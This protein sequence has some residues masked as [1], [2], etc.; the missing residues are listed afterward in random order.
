M[1][2]LFPS[3]PSVFRLLSPQHYI[4]PAGGDG[5]YLVVDEKGVFRENN[6]Q[7]ALAQ[8]AVAADKEASTRKGEHTRVARVFAIAFRFRRRFGWI[9]SLFCVIVLKFG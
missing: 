9:F 1:T 7:K 6:F 2:S 4:F 3:P 8:I 5:L